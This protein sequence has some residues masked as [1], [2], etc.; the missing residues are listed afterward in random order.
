MAGLVEGG[1]RRSSS[2]IMSCARR[3]A[4]IFSSASAKSR[5][6]SPTRRP[7]LAAIRAASLTRLRRSAPTM[8]GVV[9]ASRPGR[10]RGRAAPCGC[11][12]GGSPARPPGRA[13]ARPTVRSKRPGRIRAGSRTSGRLVAAMHDH[14]FGAGEAVH[15]G[16]DLVEGLLALVVAAEDARAAAGPA[17]GVD[18]VDEDDRRGDLARLVEQVADPA[19]ADA[20]D[21][22]DELRGAELRRTGPWP[23]RRPPGPAGSC[24]CRAG[25]RA[26]RPWA[27]V[28]PSRRYCR[29]P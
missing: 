29:G 18:L 9:E 11:G 1:P 13:G 6:A 28:A 23:R 12:P 20:D 10:H 22:L 16:E 7:R 25:R 26:A 14:A 15:L 21:H 8:P 19:G 24:R 2:G 4:A 5:H 17:D 3:R 27:C